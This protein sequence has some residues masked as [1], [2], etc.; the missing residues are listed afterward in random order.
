[1][2][3]PEIPVAE[4][5][6][7]LAEGVPLFDVRQPDEFA[8]ARVPGAVLVPLG[9]VPASLD[10]FPTDRTVYVICRSG[11]RSMKAA[12]LLRANGVDAVNIEGGTLAWVTSGLAYD[13]DA[14][15]A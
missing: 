9:D 8:E 10:Q 3:V 2:S 15:T 6:A 14:P 11:G 13:T 1:M 12:E 4:L 5:E 7:L